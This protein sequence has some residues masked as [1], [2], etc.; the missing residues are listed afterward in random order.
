MKWNVKLKFFINIGMYEIQ[1]MLKLFKNN[2]C[3]L[4]RVSLKFDRVAIWTFT[5]CLV[6]STVKKKK[7]MNG[8]GCTSMKIISIRRGKRKNC[9]KAI[10]NLR[11][12]KIVSSNHYR[13][14]D[15]VTK[16]KMLKTKF[17]WYV[18]DLW[19]WK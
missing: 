10:S 2:S 9:M 17:V 3:S 7:K 12:V 5:Q 14:V 13:T 15:S 1:N 4:K 18:Y 6:L 16:E 19:S 8:A 11:F